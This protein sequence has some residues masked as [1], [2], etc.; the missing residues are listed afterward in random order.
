MFRKFKII[1]KGVLHLFKFWK[2]LKKEKIIFIFS[3]RFG[4]FL[5]NT[6][7]LLRDLSRKNTFC[8]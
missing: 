5:Q 3:S 4:H 1:L 8:T 6:E 2:F 7:V